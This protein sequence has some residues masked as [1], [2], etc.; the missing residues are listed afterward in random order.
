VF[1][2]LPSLLAPQL[3]ALLESSPTLSRGVATLSA[4]A[5]PAGALQRRARLG[6]NCGSVS[7]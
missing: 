5:A 6:L 3:L 4:A 1:A 2:E 7:A